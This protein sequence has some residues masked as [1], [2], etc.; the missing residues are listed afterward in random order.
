MVPSLQ[1]ADV[2]LHHLAVL[3]GTGNATTTTTVV[4][5]SATTAAV[6]TVGRIAEMGAM[7][8]A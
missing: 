7:A 3:I 6:A 5:T 8:A 2:E 4:A 1:G